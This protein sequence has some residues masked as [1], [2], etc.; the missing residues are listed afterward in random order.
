[1]EIDN[2]PCDKTIKTVCP[3]TLPKPDGPYACCEDQC[4]WWHTRSLSSAIEFKGCI[5]LELS[6][7]WDI[8]IGH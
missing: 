1:M 8:G 6:N 3:M 2:L 5:I 7:L 4:A